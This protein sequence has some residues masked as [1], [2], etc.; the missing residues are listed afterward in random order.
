MPTGEDLAVYGADWD[1][2]IDQKFIKGVNIPN[3]ELRKAYSSC[4]IL[5][6]DHWEDMREK[7]FLSNRIFDGFACGALVISDNVRGGH[8][9]FGNALVT[10]ENPGE[11][12]NLIKR[13]LNDGEKE[14]ELEGIRKT[15]IKQHNYEKRAEEILEKIH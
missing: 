7:G 13:Y 9:V 3:N 2:L 12:S 15:I 8:D 4:K 1:G 5:L 14:I 10:Y 11:L 6:N